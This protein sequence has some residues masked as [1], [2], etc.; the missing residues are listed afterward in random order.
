M[1]G[2]FFYHYRSAMNGFLQASFFFG[3]M[4]MISYGA[5]LMLGAIGFF[6]ANK[7]VFYIYHFIKS[8]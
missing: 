6:S 2:T 1:Y 4:G 5:F 3:Y 8:D 7:F